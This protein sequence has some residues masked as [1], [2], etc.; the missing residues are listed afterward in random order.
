MKALGPYQPEKKAYSCSPI[1][2]DKALSRITQYYI[3][4][5]TSNVWLKSLLF[6]SAEIISK[7]YQELL[8]ELK[9]W[10]GYSSLYCLV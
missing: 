3:F 1:R 7:D 6:T 9:H 2:D 10:L 8:A 5:C 4:L